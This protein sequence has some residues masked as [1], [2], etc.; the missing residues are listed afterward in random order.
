[1]SV[2]SQFN[3]EFNLKDCSLSFILKC[4]SLVNIISDV[5]NSLT[6]DDSELIDY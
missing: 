5:V 2:N 4:Y 3:Y 6:L 1:M